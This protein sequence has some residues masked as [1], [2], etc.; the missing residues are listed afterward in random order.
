MQRP[1]RSRE[2][3][4]AVRG[5]DGRLRDGT[6]KDLLGAVE[7][8]LELRPAEL[9]V[10]ESDR[11]DRSLAPAVTVIGAWLSQRASELDLDPALLAT[12]AELTQLLQDRP[13]RLATGW[14]AELVGAP[15]QRLLRGEAS[16]VLRDG[17]RR[18]EL[19]DL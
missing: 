5:V 11:I 17:G 2:D 7:T 12:R 13:S 10:P 4:T 16:L 18:I 15:L 9:R 8:G 6:A 3:L 14:R 1:P 19:R